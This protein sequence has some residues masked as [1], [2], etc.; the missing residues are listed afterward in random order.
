VL[1][2]QCT[3]VRSILNRKQ[4]FIDSLLNG[5]GC[6]ALF[7]KIV[8]H[9]AMRIF[10][11]RCTI[12]QSVVLRLH[13]VRPSVGLTLVDKEHIGWKSWKLIARTISP[14]PSLFVPKGHPPSPRGTLEN[15]GDE[16]WGGEKWCAGA[17]KRQYL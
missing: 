7:G 5:D 10:T 8:M 2:I 4:N 9:N 13:V 15:S 3:I 1:F 16:R 6:S 17:Q 12:V 11:A 14:I